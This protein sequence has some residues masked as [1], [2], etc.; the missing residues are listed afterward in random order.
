MNFL[1]KNILVIH[2]P[3]TRGRAEVLLISLSKELVK[4]GHKITFLNLTFA[5][6]LLLKFEKDLIKNDLI[7]SEDLS[8]FEISLTPSRFDYLKLFVKILPKLFNEKIKSLYISHD[9][10]WAHAFPASF[11]AS[12]LSFLYGEKDKKIIYTHHFLKKKEPL[13]INF[14][15]TQVLNRFDFIVGV[16]ELTTQS[17]K[18]CFPKLSKKIISI[19]NGIELDKFLITENKEALRKKLELPLNTPIAICVARFTPIKNQIFLVKVLEKFRNL[20]L[21]TIGEGSELNKFLGKIKELRLEDNLVHLGFIAHDLIPF[22]LHASDL[23]LFPSKGEGFSVAVVE[24][25]ASGLP[26]VIF[27][28]VYSPELED[29]ILVA[30]NE[31]EF[32]RLV[33]DL[34]K[35]SRLRLEMQRKALKIAKKF[36]IKKTADEYEKLFTS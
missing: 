3:L 18:S 6:D 25:L 33:E 32:I 28:E 21:I 23:F 16:G 34:L 22:Y 4:R 10:I 17:L 35:N 14:F 27:K 29:G 9:V 26:T 7:K 5:P 2:T 36:D 12:I 1:K 8:L 13:F 20:K 31:K 15:Y 11:V 30:N 24:A 19:S